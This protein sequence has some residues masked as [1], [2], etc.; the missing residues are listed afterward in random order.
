MKSHHLL[1]YADS[2][3]LNVACATPADLELRKPRI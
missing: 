1:R 2:R 3:F